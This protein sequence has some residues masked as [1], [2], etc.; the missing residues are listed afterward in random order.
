MKTCALCGLT[1]PVEEFGADKYKRGGRR[2]RCREC[3]NAMQRE[4]AAQWK[5]EHGVRYE[6]RYR[7]AQRDHV[8]EWCGTT[9]KRAGHARACSPECSQAIR[10][11][12][13]KEGASR[14]RR[15]RSKLDRAARGS[16]GRR[17]FIS[18]WC[19]SCARPFILAGKASGYFCSMA[20]KDRDKRARRRARKAKAEIEPISR[21]QVM[22]R[23]KHRC[24]LCGRKVRQNAVVPHPLAPTLDHV[25][26]LAEGGAHTMANIQL[27]HFLCNSIKSNGA[28]PTGEQLALVG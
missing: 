26:P 2:S 15:A 27:A 20:C 25:V 5:A 22:R 16:S 17:R 9:F 11:R 19:R 24:Q 10:A 3:T 12:E 4:F 1:K 21:A 8:C 23:D 13:G 18:A 14:W 6:R 28:W 7:Q